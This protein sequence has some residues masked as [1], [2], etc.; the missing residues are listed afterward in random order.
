MDSALTLEKA[1][2]AIRQC[3]AIQDNKS[4]WRGNSS[5]GPIKVDAVKGTTKSDKHFKKA[6]TATTPKQWSRCGKEN[7]K[8]DKFLARDVVCHKCHKKGHYNAYC[9]SK[10]VAN[11]TMTSQQTHSDNTFLDS[12]GSDHTTS[13]TVKLGCLESVE[14]TTG[15]EYWNGLGQDLCACM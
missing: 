9:L 2:T 5:F 10:S 13:W 8:R 14:W 11:V 1:K 7:Q 3:E 6:M 15:M 4:L 12:I